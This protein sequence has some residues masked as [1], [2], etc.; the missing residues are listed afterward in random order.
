MGESSTPA[1]SIASHTRNP[2]HQGRQ[3]F[4]CNLRSFRCPV[5]LAEFLSKAWPRSEPRPKFSPVGFRWGYGLIFEHLHSIRCRVHLEGFR[6]H[7]WPQGGRKL[8]PCNKHRIAHTTLPTKGRGRQRCDANLSVTV[9]NGLH[10]A[11]APPPTQEQHL[12]DASRADFRCSLRSLRCPTFL[13]EI[14][15]A[16]V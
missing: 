16:H 1:T 15:R 5:F 14:G 9:K 12:D 4:W 3:G 7:V 13:A 10:Q 6:R 2:P 11:A 8:D